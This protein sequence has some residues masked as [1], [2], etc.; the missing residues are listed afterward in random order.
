MRMYT[1]GCSRLDSAQGPTGGICWRRGGGFPGGAVE[2]NFGSHPTSALLT[3]RIHRCTVYRFPPAPPAVPPSHFLPSAAS[4]PS[5]PACGPRLK[6]SRR[7]HR[8]SALHSSPEW[9]AQRKSD[10]GG[11]GDPAGARFRVGRTILATR[12][13]RASLRTAPEP[14][15]SGRL[16]WH[17]WLLRSVSSADG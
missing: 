13:G 2:Q 1:S 4:S 12:R 10:G 3:Q 16:P 5:A 6:G 11:V 14:P 17:C 8:T 9:P 15:T 7:S